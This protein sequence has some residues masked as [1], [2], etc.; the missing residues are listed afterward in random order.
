[1]IT[2]LIYVA[3]ISFASAIIIF[4]SLPALGDPAPLYLLG[5]ILE[6]FGLVGFIFILILTYLLIIIQYWRLIE[7]NQVLKILGIFI[8]PL[9]LVFSYYIA[10]PHFITNRVIEVLNIWRIVGLTIIANFFVLGLVS[11]FTDF[12]IPQEIILIA[13]ILL[14]LTP[15][16]IFILILYYY[17]ESLLI[18]NATLLATVGLY[19]DADVSSEEVETY[20]ARIVDYLEMVKDQIKSAG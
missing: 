2:G 12:G 14:P 15:T 1:I 10:K 7:L 5:V 13:F 8:A 19:E 17:P 18:D 4:L 9:L 11:A 20:G 3:S 6:V 16:S